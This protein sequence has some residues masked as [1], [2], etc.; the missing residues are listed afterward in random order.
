MN[1]KGFY[2]IHRGRFILVFAMVAIGM[3]IDASTQYLMTPAYNNLKNLNFSG[4]LF[5]LILS[6]VLDLM[7][8]LLI[9]GSDYLFSQQTQNYL[10][11]I[12]IKIS[13]FIFKNNITE[14]AKVQ[15]DLN[16]NLDQLTK[17]Y[18]TPLKNV[19]MYA[20]DVVLSIIILFYF[21][22]SLAILTLILT[23]ISLVLPKLFENMTSKATIQVTEKNKS[24]LNSIAK[25]IN[26]LDELRRYASFDIF[27]SSLNQS[28]TAYKKAAIKQGQIV[29]G[30]VMTTIAFSSTV[31][32]GITY[33]V[34][35]WNLI[36]STKELNQKISAMEKPVKITKN[37]H[38][39]QNIAELKIENLGLHFPNGEKI[40]YPDLEVKKGEKVLLLGDSGTGKSTLFKLILG[41]LKPTQGKIS[42]VDEQGDLNINSDEIGYVAQDGILFPGSIQDNITMFDPKLNKLAEK[43]VQWVDLNKDIEKFPAGIKTA[44][45]LDQD[46]LSGGQKQKIILAR[47]LVHQTKWLFIDEGTSA[48]DSEA[49]KKVLKNLLKTD[50]TIVMIAHNFSNELINAFDRK[51]VLSNG[52][53]GETDEL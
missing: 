14:T 39:D 10:H 45:D 29:F 51:I 52:Q 1:I 28:T 43:A 32:N 31:M 5:F 11:K 21:N 26:G 47:A 34:S 50:R 23:I 19:Y 3:A 37:Q 18:A 8:L 17:N 4:F 20:L 15:N 38:G 7:R 9:S 2:E 33:L 30:A 27:N 12:R 22:W 42:F 13:R 40:T 48:I 25:W 16:A 44:V 36:K 6:Q 24:L 41:K 49:T 35:E 46:N 53:A